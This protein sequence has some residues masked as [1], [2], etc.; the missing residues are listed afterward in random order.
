MGTPLLY[1][2]GKR[3]LLFVLLLLLLLNRAPMIDV[4]SS[5]QTFA[6]QPAPE[7][8]G[9][10]CCLQERLGDLLRTSTPC[11]GCCCRRACI[12]PGCC[13]ARNMLLRSRLLRL[14]PM[15]H[16]TSCTPGRWSFCQQ[17]L[18]LGALAV[19]QNS[20]IKALHRQCGGAGLV[21]LHEAHCRM[22]DRCKGSAREHKVGLISY[23][24]ARTIV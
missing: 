7:M 21:I 3:L 6:C 8:S 11:A 10:S 23:V 14:R 24:R 5:A 17:H 22:W 15:G 12:L 4:D 2:R 20:T 9:P 13:I 19:V 1:C 16:A 18:E